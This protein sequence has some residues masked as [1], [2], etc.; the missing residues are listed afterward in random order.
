M[1]A[2]IQF[3][4]FFHIARNKIIFKSYFK[5]ST[6]INIRPVIIC[7]FLRFCIYYNLTVIRNVKTHFDVPKPTSQ[8]VTFAG[9]FQLH[10]RFNYWTATRTKK[11]Q[12]W[13]KAVCSIPLI[14]VMNCCNIEK[15]TGHVAA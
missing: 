9:K 7:V 13:M 8:T 1:K 5:F 10:Y 12:R 11:T 4:F 14:V 6:T 15:S 3:Q 2:T